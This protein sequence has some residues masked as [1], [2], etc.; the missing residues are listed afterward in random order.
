MRRKVVHIITRLDFGGAQQNTLHT[1]RTLDRGR[2]E[3]V[4]ICGEGGYLDAEARDLP[5]VKVVFLD[6]LVRDVSPARDLLALLELRQLLAAMRPD[7]VHTHSSKA[8]ILGRLAAALAGVPVII[9]TYHGF[10][11]HDRQVQLVRAAYVLLERLCALFTT[12]LVFVSDANRDYAARHRI[13]GAAEGALIRSGI[14]LGDYPAKVDAPA[15]KTS[16]GIGMHKPLVVCIG[17]LKPQKNAAD[18]VAA[19]AVASR[20]VPDAHFILIGDGPNKHALQARAFALG[21][22]GRFHFLGW[23]R[24][25]AQWLAAADVFA[26]TSLWEGLPRALVE[27]LVSGVP[28]VCYATDGV[29]DVLKDSDNGFLIQAGDVDR[30]ADRL[31]LLLSDAGLRSKMSVAAADSI[32]PAFDIDGM[33]RSQE[34]LYESLLAE[35][36]GRNVPSVR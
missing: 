17:N 34:T 3:A 4:L 20:R 21:L 10:G 30:F 2:Y 9:H 7:I 32:G 6:S 15:L 22:E 11:F 1:V 27:A 13:S 29:S 25:A 16:A 36:I 23:R 14:R 8:G 19:A 33:V 12:R 35:R 28:A 31:V 18:F 5:G 26:L 24:D